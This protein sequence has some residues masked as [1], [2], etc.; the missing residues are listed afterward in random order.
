[1]DRIFG[2][3]Q[4]RMGFYKEDWSKDRRLRGIFVQHRRRWVQS[5]FVGIQGTKNLAEYE[6]ADF[7]KYIFYII[8]NF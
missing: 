1:M 3:L 2:V 6:K 8:L 4:R 7:L 5:V